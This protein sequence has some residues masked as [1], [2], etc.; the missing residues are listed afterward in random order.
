M[1]IF[2]RPNKSL[3]VATIGIVL[4]LLSS[5][6]LH[7]VALIIGTFSGIIWSYQEVISGVNNIRKAFGVIG[8]I[9]LAILLYLNL[10]Q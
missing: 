5:G 4:S 8:F 7:N 1:E 9:T 6:F 3:T 10:P 2:Q